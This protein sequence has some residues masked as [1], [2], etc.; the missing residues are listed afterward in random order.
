MTRN[1]EKTD[2]SIVLFYSTILMYHSELT[3][4]RYFLHD[5]LIWTLK[6]PSIVQPNQK[7]NNSEVAILFNLLQLNAMGRMI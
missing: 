3:A 7:F 6:F 1:L 2:Q 4:Q 5:N